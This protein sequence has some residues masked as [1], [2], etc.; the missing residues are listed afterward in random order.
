MINVFTCV[1]GREDEEDDEKD[2]S[3]DEEKEEEKEKEKMISMTW[4]SNQSARYTV[5]GEKNPKQM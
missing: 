3:E 1:N 5:K 2:D 4:K